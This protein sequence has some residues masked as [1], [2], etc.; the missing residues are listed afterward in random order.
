MTSS[1]KYFVEAGRMSPATRLIAITA[2]PTA[3]RP[4]RGLMNTQT[5]GRSSRRRAGF[6]CLA[7]DS[8]LGEALINQVDSRY[9]NAC[10]NRVAS[11]EWPG[12]RLES[13]GW[14]MG[15]LAPLRSPERAVQLQGHQNKGPGDDKHGKDG[16]R[17]PE[18][19][20]RSGL[21]F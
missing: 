1:T 5:S 19:L 17:V 12:D 6:S 21:R 11:A 14:R 18:V 3:S 9:R 10:G 20:A 4:R 16:E 2:N 8:G 13:A 7:F 15:F